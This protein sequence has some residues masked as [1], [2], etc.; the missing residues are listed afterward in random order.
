MQPVATLESFARSSAISADAT[1]RGSCGQARMG[2]G[3]AP[4]QTIQ[5]ETV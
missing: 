1:G 4:L 2:E 5:A 3:F